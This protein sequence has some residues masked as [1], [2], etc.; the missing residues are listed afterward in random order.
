MREINLGVIASELIHW[1]GGVDFLK[2]L[3]TGISSINKQLNN[4]YVFCLEEDKS[5]VK[6]IL[7]EINSNFV[8]IPLGENNVNKE[9][10]IEKIKEKD[11]HCL[12]PVSRSLGEGFPISTIGYIP[13]FQ[14]KYYP[15]FFSKS[16]IIYRDKVFSNL[17]FDTTAIL[18]NSRAVCNDVE[19]YYE[20]LA[21]KTFSLPF[22]PIFR[23]EW[24][25][26]NDC[27]ILSKYALPDN[28]F[29]ISNQFWMHKSHRTAFTALKLLYSNVNQYQN[30][31]LVCTGNPSDYR[32]NNYFNELMSYIED[33]GITKDILFLGYIPKIDQIAIMNN[34]LAVIQ[35]STF[36]GGPG[37][38]SAYD[39]IAIGKPVIMSDIPVNLEVNKG[40]VLFFKTESPEDLANKMIEFLNNSKKKEV[41]IDF[42]L[43]VSRENIE[44]LGSR[45]LEC[46]NFSVE[47]FKQKYNSIKDNI[48][49]CDNL[50]AIDDL[51]GKDFLCIQNKDFQLSADFFRV[52]NLYTNGIHDLII[53]GLRVLRKNG[54]SFYEDINPS[55]LYKQYEDN[56]TLFPYI[57]TNKNLFSNDTKYNKSIRYINDSLVSTTLENYIINILFKDV[58]QNSN[59]YIYGGGTHTRELLKE[60][61]FEK[62]NL[63]GIIDNNL[64]LRGT[65][66]NTTPICSLADIQDSNVDLILIS[67]AAYEEEIY[68]DL[69][70][71]FSGN[72]IIKLYGITS[73]M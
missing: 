4:V 39:A 35:P 38:G 15:D 24:K 60:V 42:L 27:T 7:E 9:S 16:E 67:S 58:P 22:G 37:G 65:S 51:N 43:N 44:N 6:L 33:L 41:S 61:N 32:N 10:L 57:I 29:L 62:F 53:S 23:S 31:K 46:I 69:K 1:G 34:A 52:A 64:D 30:I 19:K 25:D 45:L 14:H 66:I 71:K 68:K 49:F 54:D 59:L 73:Q 48:Y 2:Y 40:E 26:F 3:L 47:S 21:T 72:K 55:Y 20:K 12:L 50:H 70:C 63:R 5:K 8:V 11:I 36:E 13:D 17:L 28:Y 18:V 56:A